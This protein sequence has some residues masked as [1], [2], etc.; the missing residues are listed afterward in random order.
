MCFQK[1]KNI[2]KEYKQILLI[3]TLGLVGIFLYFLFLYYNIYAYNTNFQ[4]NKEATKKIND[5][6]YTKNDIDFLKANELLDSINT[7]YLEESKYNNLLLKEYRGFKK[8]ELLGEYEKLLTKIC[9]NEKWERK[10]KI[11]KNIV[12]ICWRW[13]YNL[14]KTH[15]TLAVENSK[16]KMFFYK[17]SIE[18]F[19]LSN[20][21][22]ANADIQRN[23][24]NI[25]NI[26]TD[27]NTFQSEYDEFITANNKEKNLTDKNL[28]QQLD[29]EKEHENSY[30][31][32]IADV[33]E[34]SWISDEAPKD[35]KK[36]DWNLY[37]QFTWKDTDELKDPENGADNPDYLKDNIKTNSRIQGEGLD[38][39]K[40]KENTIENPYFE[41]E[42][43][44]NKI[45]E[46]ETFFGDNIQEKLWNKIELNDFYIDK[47]IMDE[48]KYKRK[49]I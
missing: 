12:E 14:A 20:T 32:N 45:R 15:M 21:F 24:Q 8:N 48:I 23:F 36:P 31:K 44:E 28:A 30:K 46:E 5:Y 26:L 17:K 19:T 1:M 27:K 34:D 25:E 43:K 11:K 47:L 18:T 7:S 4:I 37:W 35:G 2:R 33:T 3:L 38:H 9:L 16:N 10:E 22:K 49:K 6:I 41:D 39:R 42:E 40:Y 29:G 13:Y